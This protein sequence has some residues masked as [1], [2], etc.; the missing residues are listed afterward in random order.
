[1]LFRPDILLL[2]EVTSA[3]DHDNVIL[4]ELAIKSFYD[5]GTTILW[6]THNL[7]QSKRHANR[8][9]NMEMG[10]VSFDDNG[11]GTIDENAGSY[12]E[13]IS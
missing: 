4:M 9:I 1:M 10:K 13:D 8:I 12:E 11:N 5:E 3:L 7:E 2:D 6:I